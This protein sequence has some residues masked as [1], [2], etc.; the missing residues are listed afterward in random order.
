MRALARA[1]IQLSQLK[2][3]FAPA[4]APRR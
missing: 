1:A 2:K 3:G 4:K